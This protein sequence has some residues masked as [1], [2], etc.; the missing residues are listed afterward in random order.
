MQ[1]AAITAR[2]APCKNKILFK[3][4]AKS[5]ILLG[6]NAKR[7]HYGAKRPMQNQNFV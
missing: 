4:D 5:L 2:N 1:N 7:S 3:N 6:E